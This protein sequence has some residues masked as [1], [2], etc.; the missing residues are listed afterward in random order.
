[1]KLEG[2]LSA[3]MFP[4][5]H[6]I[7]T[8]TPDYR[9]CTPLPCHQALDIAV[10]A[11]VWEPIARITAHAHQRVQ[12]GSIAICCSEWERKQRGTCSF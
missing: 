11:P 5:E 3:K 10:V 8:S 12:Q 1:M 7:P 4:I 9:G 6:E 2:Y